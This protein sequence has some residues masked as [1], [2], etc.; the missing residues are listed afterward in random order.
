MVQHRHIYINATHIVSLM[1]IQFS[2][3]HK[4]LRD[5]GLQVYPALSQYCIRARGVHAAFSCLFFAVL[6]AQNGEPAV[7][8]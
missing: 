5:L 8:Q 6:A 2:C 1:S 4:A 3:R 7:V